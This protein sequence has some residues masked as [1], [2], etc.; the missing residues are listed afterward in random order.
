MTYFLSTSPNATFHSEDFLACTGNTHTH[1]AW[2]HIYKYTLPNTQEGDDYI[3][4]FSG[5]QNECK[6]CR[7]VSHVVSLQE[8]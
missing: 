3:Y 8:P 4:K 2:T 1:T 5:L 6:V 7:A